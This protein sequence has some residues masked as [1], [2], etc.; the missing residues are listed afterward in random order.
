[1]QL[2]GPDSYYLGIDEMPLYNWDKCLSG[3]IK[4]VR[5]G[6][7]GNVKNDNENWIKIYDEYLREFGLSKMHKKLLDA[8]KEKALHE[9]DYVIT[10]DKFKLTLIEMAESKLKQIIEIN[11]VGVT[12]EQT[13]IHVS[14]WIGYR[15][16]PR[17]ISVK[18]YFYLLKEFEKA[19]KTENNIMKNGKKNK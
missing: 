14:K 10:E 9:C 1:M 12:T 13:M 15:I 18:E 4:F 16:N 7:N 6:K 11:K 8:L 19:M 5:K 2:I 3:E 17:E